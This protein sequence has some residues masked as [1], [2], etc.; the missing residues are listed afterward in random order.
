[1]LIKVVAEIEYHSIQN[2]II[3]CTN[4]KSNVIKPTMIKCGAEC[5]AMR[6]PVDLFEMPN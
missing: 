3:V 4:E 2:F 6:D 5:S 1:M